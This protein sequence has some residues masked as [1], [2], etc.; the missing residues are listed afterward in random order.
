MNRKLISKAL[1]DIDD[2]FISES[3]SLAP[4]SAD[5]APERIIKMGKYQST[6]KSTRKLI[7]LILA[8]CLVFAFAITAYAANLFGIR[9]MFKTQTRELPEAADPYI[10]QHT[11]TVAAEGW[12][13]KISES[14][15]DASTIMA[16]VTVYGGDQYI[17]APTYANPD[18]NVELIGL[19]GDQTLAEYA[20]AQ[21]KQLLL[22]GATFRGNEGMDVQIE[23]E[24]AVCISDNEVNLLVQVERFVGKITN[25]VVCRV[26]AVD[27]SGA[28]LE[29][30]LPITLKE[31]PASDSA[32]YVPVNPDA[33]PGL[34]VGKASVTE[35][36]LGLNIQWMETCTDEKALYDIMYIEIEGIEDS[37]GGGGV[38]EDDG[39][40]YFSLTMGQGTVGDTMTAHFYDWD[41]QLIGDIIFQ[42]K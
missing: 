39:N 3:M 10:Q 33:I 14:L 7:A 25:P 21:G 6:G 20:S 13:A 1:S 15:C 27:E 9:E 16:T 32:V 18:D 23:G 19:K 41:K 8:A 35:T 5:Q 22:V 30:K 17:I 12:S 40:W 4:T 2:A 36:P 31:A 26:Y 11:E 24:N 28:L 37:Q 42:K 29:L 34:T 38:L